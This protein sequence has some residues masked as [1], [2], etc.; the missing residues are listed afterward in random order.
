MFSKNHFFITKS[1][2]SV[3]KTIYI[4]ISFSFLPFIY[5]STRNGLIIFIF[6]CVCVCYMGGLYIFLWTLLHPSNRCSKYDFSWEKT[7]QKSYRHHSH[8]NYLRVIWFL[9]T[10]LTIF[11]VSSESES[12]IVPVL[13]KAM[14]CI[15]QRTIYINLFLFIPKS[16]RTWCVHGRIY[17]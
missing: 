7:I 6:L 8:A 10:L 12:L 16:M 4:C 15:T 14:M 17:K 9:S 1:L 3:G 13:E 11:Q 2:C 5:S